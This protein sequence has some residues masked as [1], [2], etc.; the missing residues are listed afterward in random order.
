VRLSYILAPATA[1]AHNH[2][3]ITCLSVRMSVSLVT[4]V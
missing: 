3:Y 4:F 1:D 2:N